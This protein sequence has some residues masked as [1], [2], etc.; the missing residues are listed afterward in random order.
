[1]AGKDI[2][3]KKGEKIEYTKKQKQHIDHDGSFSIKHGQVHYGYK[4]HT[5]SDVGNQLI[6]SYEVSTASLHDAEVDLVEEGDDT[7]YRDKGYFGRALNAEGVSNKTMK[8]A[9]KNRKLNGGE[10]LRNKAIS[11][12]RAPGERPYGVVKR[13]FHNNRTLVKTLERVSIKQMFTYFAYN[14]YQ[15]VTL[16]RNEIAI[17]T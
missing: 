4:T 2:T 7:A 8:R 9:T 16:V 6:R 5:K 1:M 11:R 15:L 10:Q 17:A 3:R 12:I 14:L 13:V